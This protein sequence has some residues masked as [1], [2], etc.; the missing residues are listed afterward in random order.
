MPAATEAIDC[1]PSDKPAARRAKRRMADKSVG[2]PSRAAVLA[3]AICMAAALPSVAAGGPVPESGADLVVYGK[4]FT[5]EGGK[6]AEAFAVKD[7]RYVYVGDRAGADAY[8]EEGWTEVVDRTGRGLV[9]PGCGNGHAHYIPAHA[10]QTVGTAM[11]PDTD[12]ERFFDEVVPAAVK[13]ARDAGAT[14]VFGSGWDAF[15][16]PLDVA[17]R[18]RLDAICG[19]LP[20]YFADEEGHKGLAN[21]ILLKKAGIIREDGSAGKTEMRGGEIVLDAYGVPTGYLKESAGW[22][23]CGLEDG[24]VVVRQSGEREAFEGQDAGGVGCVQG[25]CEPLGTE[26]RLHAEAGNVQGLVQDVRA[27]GHGQEGEAQEAHRQR[28]RPCGGR[29]RLREGDVQEAVCRLDGRGAIR[30]RFF[31][32]RRALTLDL[33]LRTRGVGCNG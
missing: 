27:G 13:K 26:A 12:L 32:A 24:Q 30:M 7:G 23:A 16:F 2:R 17:Y 9:M 28:D 14:S 19:D 25:K 22:R 4:I 3:A 10:I 6:I 33:D 18:E 5:A 31:P 8:V 20:V 21:T 1:V 11:S 15:R 29:H